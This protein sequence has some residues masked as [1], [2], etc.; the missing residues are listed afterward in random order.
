MVAGLGPLGLPVAVALA[1]AGY[2]VTGLE[3]N[4]ARRQQARSQGI[5]V[6]EATP[7]SRLWQ[8]ADAL[9]TVLPDDAAVSDLLEG[10]HGWLAHQIGRAH[11]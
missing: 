2:A 9:L 3:I 10:L 7:D 8:S 5:T 6:A 1:R 4:D 11:V